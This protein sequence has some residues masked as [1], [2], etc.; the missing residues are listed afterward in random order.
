MLGAEQIRTKILIGGLRGSGKTLLIYNSILEE[1]WKDTY[2]KNEANKKRGLD[3]GFDISTNRQVGLMPT[4]GFNCE[5]YQSQ[6]EDLALYDVSGSLFYQGELPG[7][8]FGDG[9]DY[10]YSQFLN[11][12]DFSGLVWVVDV[13]QDIEELLRSKQVLHDLVFSNQIFSGKAQ[14]SI[15]FNRKKQILSQNKDDKESD[16]IFEREEIERR[17][18]VWVEC[19]FNLEMLEKL[20][21]VEKLNTRLNTRTYDMDILERN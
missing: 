20:F 12:V 5:K 7:M 13:N 1:D 21:K 2:N 8:I 11:I 18:K 16:Q 19:P 14:L 9:S 15:V 4:E 17:L 10:G 3:M 6:Q